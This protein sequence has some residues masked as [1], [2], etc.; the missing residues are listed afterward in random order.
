MKKKLIIF[1]LII[2]TLIG[3]GFLYTRLSKKEAVETLT[4]PQVTDTKTFSSLESQES[5][6]ETNVVVNKIYNGN[7]RVTMDGQTAEF[8]MKIP[9]KDGKVT[10]LIS[11]FCNG[12]MTGTYEEKTG[13]VRGTMK[14]KCAIFPAEGDFAGNIDIKN[15]VGSGDFVGSTL[16]I[17]KTGTW[18]LNLE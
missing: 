1:L 9:E 10:G 17:K 2:F 3:A 4:Q 7:G 18:K 14:G 11:G 8:T 12:E 6:V 13:Y 15:K 5:T 16:L